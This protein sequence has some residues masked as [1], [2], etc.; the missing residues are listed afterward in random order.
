MIKLILAAGLIISFLFLGQIR[1][2]SNNKNIATLISGAEANSKI[3]KTPVKFN[4]T[5]V[6]SIS[7]NTGATNLEL[8]TDDGQN[9]QI[10]IGPTVIT[11]LPNLGER[12]EVTTH[13]LDKGLFSV[14]KKEDIKYLP[15][16]WV[17]EKPLDVVYSYKQLKPM[18]RCIVF[19]NIHKGS[20]T[21]EG[22]YSFL[23]SGRGSVIRLSIPEKVFA[24]GNCKDW[25]EVSLVGYLNHA[26]VFIVEEI[27]PFSKD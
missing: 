13:Q 8:Q 24:Q 27:R 14:V 19:G 6:R 21:R 1:L 22:F 26:K 23:Y 5:V 10:I 17:A 11:R 25:E 16:L 4:G 18:E 15:L 9:I 12:I 20:K 2:D 7:Q 3:F